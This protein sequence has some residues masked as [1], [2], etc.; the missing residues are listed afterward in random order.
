MTVS[1][2]MVLPLAPLLPLPG[3]RI[4]RC[5]Q[6]FRSRSSSF[7]G[8]QCSLLLT[9]GPRCSTSWPARNG[10]TVMCFSCARLVF[11][12]ILH[13]ALCF[14]SCLQA[15]DARH[16]G[17]YGPGEHVCSWLVSLHGPSYLAVS[18]SLF[19]LVR[20]WI[21][22]TSVYSGF[23]GRLLKMFRFQHNAWFDIHLGDDFVELLVFST[24]LGS[25]VALRDDFVENGRIQRNARF[26]V[27][28]RV[29]LEEFGFST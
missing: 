11:L 8:A 14:L 25:T 21:H 28:L 18:C 20:Q 5:G 3:V 7:S 10:R 15:R 22:V 13:F 9:T 6:V 23:C 4:R 19:S 17:R 1:L 27:S 29:L 26:G 2:L 24:M 12:A 16:H